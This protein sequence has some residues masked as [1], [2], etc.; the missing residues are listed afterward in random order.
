[1]GGI[2]IKKRL[3]FVNGHL[4]V[5]GVERSLVDLLKY[6]DYD[7]YELDLILFEELGDYI[8]EIP[9]DVNVIF[10]DLTKTYG[11]FLKC[12]LNNL[13][14]REGKYAF[15]RIVFYLER[16][17]GAKVKKLLKPLFK[18]LGKYD[19]AI[20]YRIGICTDFVAYVVNAK[21]KVTWWHH[22][23]YDYNE[24]QT[25]AIENVYKNF[26]HV[27]SVSEGC[28]NMILDNVNIPKDKIVVIPNI[29]DFDN[30]YNKSIEKVDDDLYDKDYV[31]IV[32]IGR[33]SPEKGMINC[34]FACKQL[35]DL[36]YKIK[37]FLIG[38]GSE[39]EK[40]KHEILLNDLEDK[41]YLLGRKKNPYSYLKNADVYVH[42]SYV[43]SM[44]ITVLEAMCLD[45][46]L[47]VAKSIGPLEFIKNKENGILVNPDI[48][49]LVYGI[50]SL[51]DDIKLYN[52][53]SKKDL[54]VLK[55]YT[56]ESVILNVEELIN[57]I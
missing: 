38:D 30:I 28:K 8:D 40:I 31:N 33:L 2:Y 44:S 55:N 48:E 3:L 17:F 1:M 41:V 27:V 47:V 43:E 6:I 22:G 9:N 53:L 20:A 46:P 37:W 11:S 34:V 26:N 29:I 32:S 45:K 56:F 12:I 52:K 24:K 14:N 36:G 35:I 57:K 18:S 4:N 54:N 5:G 10:Y 15:I 49:G 23:S 7:K 25:K 51:L 16:I 21:N 50:K 39:Y 13:K 19:C 42:P